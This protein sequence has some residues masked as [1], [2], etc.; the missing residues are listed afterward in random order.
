MSFIFGVRI[1]KYLGLSIKK[2]ISLL[3]FQKETLPEI[4]LYAIKFYE[5]RGNCNV[6]WLEFQGVI[7]PKHGFYRNNV[8]SKYFS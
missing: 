7:V 8:G 4:E 3:Y 6:C 1:L 5:K 2:L